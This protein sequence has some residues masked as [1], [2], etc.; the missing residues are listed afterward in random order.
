MNCVRDD[1]QAFGLSWAGYPADFPVAPVTAP[2]IARRRPLCGFGVNDAPYL[3]RPKVNGRKIQCPVYSAWENMIARCCH[4]SMQQRNPTYIGARVCD[5]WQSFMA[6]RAWV[7]SQ[8]DWQNRAVEKDMLLP[9]NKVYGPV[10]CIM[11]PQAVN[12]LFSG[13]GKQAAEQ[14]GMPTGVIKRGNRYTAMLSVYGK[15]V[16]LGTYATVAEA[17]EAHKERKLRYHVEVAARYMNEPVL[18]AAIIDNAARVYTPD[19]A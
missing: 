14:V 5:E 17:V 19:A 6:F 10:T 7:I 2:A 11:V 3:V 15:T 8:P 4:P 13:R 18:F 16:N 9:G 12:N 1:R